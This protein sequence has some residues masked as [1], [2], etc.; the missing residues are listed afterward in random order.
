M[1]KSYLSSD[2]GESAGGFN[3]NVAKINLDDFG[4]PVGGTL[5]KIV[6]GLDT[7]SGQGTKPSLSLVGAINSQNLTAIPEPA[8]TLGLL[9]LGFL[10]TASA[11]NRK[12]SQGK[13]SKQ[14]N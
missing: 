10:G 6:I 3:L 5:D 7:E 14:D 2:T 13:K 12:L 9:T 8:S 4:I 11:I 1:T